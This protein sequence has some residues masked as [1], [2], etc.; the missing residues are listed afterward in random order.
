M[1]R[2]SIVLVHG[3]IL[4]YKSI[5]TCGMWFIGHRK[6]SLGIEGTQSMGE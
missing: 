1:N 3:P 4:I 6:F 2:V 5:K